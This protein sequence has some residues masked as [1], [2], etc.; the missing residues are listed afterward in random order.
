[1]K[2]GIV[3]ALALIVLV[4]TI[5]MIINAKPPRMGCSDNGNGTVDIWWETKK[6]WFIFSHWEEGPHS[7]KP[8]VCANYQDSFDAR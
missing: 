1:M 7:A 8:G 3:V 4:S 6:G 5:P 2:K